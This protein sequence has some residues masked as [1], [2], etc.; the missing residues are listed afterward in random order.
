MAPPLIRLPRAAPVVAGLLLAL[1]PAAC[2][3]GGAAAPAPLRVGAVFPLAGPGAGAAAE[4]R[5]GVDLA[6]QIVNA[7]GGIG[8]RQI[9]LEVADAES[10]ADAAPAVH[11][12][13]AGGVPLVLG[14]FSSDLSIPA[15]AQAQR[16]G[17]VYWESGAVADQVTGQGAPLVFRVGA[18]GRELG[19]TSGGF[20][21]AQIVPRL[22]RA[23]GQVRVSLVVADDAYAHSVAAAAI[24]TLRLAGVQVA[25]VSTYN[26]GYP[27]F[28]QVLEAVRAQRP[29]VLILASHIPD[30]IAFRRAFLASGLHVDA[31]VGSTMAQCEHDFGD[32]LGQD[33]VGVFAADRPG[34]GFDPAT[35]PTA[36]ARDGYARLAQLWAQQHGGVPTEEGISGFTAAWALFHD[37]LP[38]A[39]ARGNLSPAGI[40][41]AAR[42]TELAAG[43][44]PNG[45]GLHF[46]EEPERLGQNT[47]AAAVVW[48]WQRPRFSV[49]VWPPQYATGSV[50]M[51]PL[52]A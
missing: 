38:R 50:T 11:R 34:G 43:T 37:V 21:A 32:A 5:L 39:A 13:A 19:D 27:R 49:V 20:V 8:G 29:D 46:S 51:V 24:T 36:T 28:D 2:G 42:S 40:A 17:V 22:G 10:V 31:F 9:Q 4:E 44:L 16:D 6:R 25:G 45:A 30:G 52:P 14:A 3:P 15:A 47:L 35:L 33:A 23:P 12:L 18:S 48:Q 26:L 7:D 41:A 1:A